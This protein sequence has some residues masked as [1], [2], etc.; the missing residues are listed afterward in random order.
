[1]ALTTGFLWPLPPLA[2]R[3]DP[4]E[5]HVWRIPLTPPRP[6]EASS[7]SPEELERASH[8]Y[9]ARDRD[10]F[11]TARASLRS[12]LGGYLDSDASQIG[13]RQTPWGR[14]ELDPAVHR[15][16]ARCALDF[17]LTHSGN[18]A[19]LAVTSGRKIGIDLEQIRP[20]VVEDALLPHVCSASE[21][22]LL[23]S[24]QGEERVAAFFRCWTRKES[25][26]KARGEGLILAL[27]SVSVSLGKDETPVLRSVAGDPDEVSRWSLVDLSP[28]P[29]FAACLAVSA[30]T[31]DIRVR[32]WRMDR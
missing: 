25:Y 10:R 27:T 13:L 20:Q 18:L 2:A 3:A 7:L 9:L 4:E 1:M 6:E 22:S 29:G 28:E 21:L 31:A 17:N 15:Q 14:P 16:E 26:L 23:L 11:V 30:S 8:Y 12:I 19:L 32:Q 5:V 24:L